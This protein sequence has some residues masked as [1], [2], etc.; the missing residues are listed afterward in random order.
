MKEE[1]KTPQTVTGYIEELNIKLENIE[2][3]KQ[4]IQ[5]NKTEF[6]QLTEEEWYDYKNSKLLSKT[7][8]EQLNIKDEEI[9]DLKLL[10]NNKTIEC[11]K[12]KMFMEEQDQ[13]EKEAGVKCNVDYDIFGCDWPDAAANRIIFLRERIKKLEEKLNIETDL[14]IKI[15]AENEKLKEFIHKL[16]YGQPPKCWCDVAIGNPM[17]NGKHSELCS[18]LQD[19]FIDTNKIIEDYYHD[20]EAQNL[21]AMKGGEY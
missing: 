3:E 9:K 15:K 19:Y 11:Q 12:Y 13:L 14:R 17:R 21:D 1:N 20:L 16:S 2:S 18:E 10:L 6:F 8:S 7:L 4:D 5:D